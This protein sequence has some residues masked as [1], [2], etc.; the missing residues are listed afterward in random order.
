MFCAVSLD[1]YLETLKLRHDHHIF[2]SFGPVLIKSS[3]P[4]ARFSRKLITSHRFRNH[5]A[6]R[7]V[8]GSQTRSSDIV[9]HHHRVVH[10]K[11]LWGDLVPVHSLLLYSARIERTRSCV[12]EYR[13]M[14]YSTQNWR[15]TIAVSILSQRRSELMKTSAIRHTL[16]IREG[17]VVVA[18]ERIL[19]HSLI[20]TKTHLRF[21]ARA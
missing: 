12:C 8:E 17:F 3:F 1:G 4:L 13:Y 2:H 10:G 16:V 7:V 20:V 19:P 21:L 18:N 9:I 14:N 15:T 5:Y 11:S 6:R